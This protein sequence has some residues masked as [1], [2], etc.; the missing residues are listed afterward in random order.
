MTN[1]ACDFDN[2]VMTS[3]RPG[4]RCH[5]GQ[6]IDSTVAALVLGQKSK[7]NSTA[8]QGRCKVFRPT[9]SHFPAHTGCD[10]CGRWSDGGEKDE[11]RSNWREWP[12][13][14]E[15]CEQASSAGS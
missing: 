14:D 4:G 6:P 11:D 10:G 5:R 2:K 9:R 1:S 13:R 7:P 8:I 15:P 3:S 12:H